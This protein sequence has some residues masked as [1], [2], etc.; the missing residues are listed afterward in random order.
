[1]D[2]KTRSL[3]ASADDATGFE[4]PGNDWGRFPGGELEASVAKVHAALASELGLAFERDRHVQDASFFDQLAIEQR[5]DERSSAV[6]LGI[7]FSNFGRLFT[8]Y[9]T[10]ESEPHAYDEAAIVAL[11][12]RHGWRYVPSDELE[13]PY[14][15]ANARMRDGETTWWIRFFDYL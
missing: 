3:L 9:T 5:L 2:P 14:D 8:L 11:V 10:T 13:A 4:V 1:M 7:R 6:A 12:E 15:G